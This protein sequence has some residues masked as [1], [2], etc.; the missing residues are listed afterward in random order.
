MN[1]GSRLENKQQLIDLTRLLLLG[2][3]NYG[4]IANLAAGTGMHLED[5]LELT[6]LDLSSQFVYIRQEVGSLKYPIPTH[7]MPQLIKPLIEGRSQDERVFLKKT[8]EVYTMEEVCI[9]LGNAAK[10]VGILNF[11][12]E[13]FRKWYFYNVWVLSNENIETIQKVC[14]FEKEEEAAEYIGVKLKKGIKKLFPA[15]KK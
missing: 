4:Y 14:G 8:G 11:G 6:V 1:K 13:S 5:I 12:T 3:K 7:K 2:D 9:E 10:Q 15:L